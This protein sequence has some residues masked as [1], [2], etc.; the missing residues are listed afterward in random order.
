MM[1]FDLGW[2]SIPLGGT[3]NLPPTLGHEIEGEVVSIRNEVQ[4]IKVGENVVA[5]LG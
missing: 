4:D 5:F 3:M 1:V 2:K